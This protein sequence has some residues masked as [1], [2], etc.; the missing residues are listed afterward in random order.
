MRFKYLKSMLENNIIDNSSVD[1]S[2]SRFSILPFRRIEKRRARIPAE[3]ESRGGLVWPIEM[4]VDDRLVPLILAVSHEVLAIIIPH[5]IDVDSNSALNELEL[6]P[7]TAIFSI[8]PRSILG[9]TKLGETS[10][11]IYF[12]KGDSFFFS[13]KRKSE[14]PDLLLRLE[15]ASRG[16]PP[17]LHP[18]AINSKEINVTRP[19]SGGQLGFHVAYE[20][21]V[22]QVDVGSAA[23]K[24]GLQKGSRIV[25]IQTKP[26]SKLSHKEMI[27]ILRSESRVT[28]RVLPPVGLKEQP[29]YTP[30]ELA[31]SVPRLPESI[32]NDERELYAE[33]DDQSF[34]LWYVIDYFL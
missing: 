8:P 29:R 32:P 16:R 18:P 12:G 14:I 3:I 25:A 22:N 13:V 9:W 27:D 7:G 2:N 34:L 1:G 19:S 21:F 30:R 20:G 33:E 31:N 26:L 11:E 6:V 24:S 5:A 23:A 15:C 17:G 10:I 28:L 4:L